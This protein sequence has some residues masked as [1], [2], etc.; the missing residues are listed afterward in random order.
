M[1][2]PEIVAFDHVF[3]KRTKS[4]LKQN[5]SKYDFTLLINSLVGLLILP[6]EYYKNKKAKPRFD[7]FKGKIADLKDPLKSI[8]SEDKITIHQDSEIEIQKC[9]F[10]TN[11]GSVK[12]ANQV[13]I[14]ELMSKLRS[15]IAHFNI[16]P[17]RSGNDWEGVLL[18]NTNRN[19]IT[20]MEL[21]LK[22]N[23]LKDIIFYIIEKYESCYVEKDK[24]NF[25]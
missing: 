16:Q 20:T 12:Q 24:R 14:Y 3:I 17:T 8:F 18:K 1:G 4:I 25:T 7:P 10:R 22:Q 19:N 13:L 21:Y 2:Y 15:S 6:N 5:N 23:E 9:V 11:E